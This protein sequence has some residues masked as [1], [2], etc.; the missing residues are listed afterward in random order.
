[1][2]EFKHIF[3]AAKKAKK[4]KRKKPEYTP[5]VID[6]N[7]DEKSRFEY[8]SETKNPDDKDLPGHQSKHYYKGLD[9]ETKE[10]REKHF[11]KQTKMNWKDP[12]AYKDAP[13]DEDMKTKISKHTKK[14]RKM[15]G[16]SIDDLVYKILDEEY[17]IEVDNKKVDNIQKN[18]AYNMTALAAAAALIATKVLIDPNYAKNNKGLTA[19]FNDSL[20]RAMNVIAG[21]TSILQKLKANT[22]MNRGV[23][24]EDNSL[25]A[26]SKKSG[27]P[28]SILR[29][30][31]NRGLA[32]WRT[33]H[34]PGASQHAWAHA[35][36]NSFITKGKGTWGGADKDLS[37]KVK[38][39]KDER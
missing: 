20:Q 34:R 19:R 16:E 15:F 27:I 10:K 30:V 22:N 14:Y 25:E 11:K 33:G 36:V 5:I 29:K 31:Y 23:M 17:I 35:R 2:L 38:G 18:M 39:K 37:N 12:E 13:G 28:L 8:V 3:E 9:K 7:F 6:P 21:D 32:A 1:M 4:V 24:S 26:K